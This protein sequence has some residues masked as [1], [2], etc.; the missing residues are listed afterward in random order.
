M[1]LAYRAWTNTHAE[2][3]VPHP[4]KPANH[5]GL[6][7]LPEERQKEIGVMRSANVNNWLKEYNSDKSAEQRSRSSSAISEKWAD[8]RESRQD[9]LGLRR[10]IPGVPQRTI[11]MQFSDW[12][13][14]RYRHLF[15][16]RQVP[17]SGQQWFDARVKF[18]PERT[19]A[20]EPELR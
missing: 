12:E 16:P 6:R 14:D 11:S 17:R 5:G 10:G 8:A 2:N 9:L 3:N 7:H 13:F 20:V 4:E 19:F 18:G 1:R 15:R